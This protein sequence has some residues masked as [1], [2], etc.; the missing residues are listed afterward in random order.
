MSYRGALTRGGAALAGMTVLVAPA[1]LL[2]LASCSGSSPAPAVR[3]AVVTRGDVTA[4]VAANGSF[5]AVSSENLGFAT[6]GRL[7]SVTVKVGDRVQG[8]DLLA[9]LDSRAAKHALEQAEAN[10]E[11]QQAGLDRLTAATTVAGAQS[12]VDQARNVVSATK[13]QVAATK[14]ADQAAIDRAQAQLSSDRDARD[15]AESAAARLKDSCRAAASG[16]AASAASSALLQQAEQQLAAGDTAGA[17]QTLQ[18]LN[19]QLGAGVGTGDAAACTQVLTAES[20]VSAAKQKVVAD[21]TVLVSA[22]QKKKVDA[23]SG[24]LAVENAE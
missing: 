8:G 21:K 16:A 9:T 24:K 4:G 22:Q 11:A 10:L 20:A 6:G 1:M 13:G 14:E 7:T 17:A 2:T 19:G 15:Q 18:Q 12:S 3:S 23:A 5:A